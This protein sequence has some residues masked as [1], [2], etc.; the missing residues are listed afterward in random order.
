ML[1]LNYLSAMRL[2]AAPSASQHHTTYV[3]L[4]TEF[5][6]EWYCKSDAG[7]VMFK[8]A[9]LFR[10]TRNGTNIASDGFVEH[11]VFYVRVYCG[12]KAKGMYHAQLVETVSLLMDEKLRA[13]TVAKD[14]KKIKI[15]PDN[16]EGL[17]CQKFD[18]VMLESFLYSHD[19]NLFGEGPPRYVP[20]VP[21]NERKHPL[22]IQS[23]HQ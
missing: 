14:E 3:F 16:E 22:T 4:L 1:T 5:F 12:K 18:K 13:K 11:N 19:Q 10:Q 8:K 21:Q 20:S 9:F 23:G 6:V 7:K 15:Y 2:L 17:Q